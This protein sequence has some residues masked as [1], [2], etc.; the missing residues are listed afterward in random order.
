MD[1]FFKDDENVVNKEV[2]QANDDNKGSDYEGGE[3]EESEQ[4]SMDEASGYKGLE[5]INLETDT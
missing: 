5:N 4:E 3:S 2:E 1:I